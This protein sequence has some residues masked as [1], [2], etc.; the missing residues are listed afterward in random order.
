MSK[1]NIRQRSK[2]DRVPYELWASQGLITLTYAYIIDFDVIESSI[3]NDAKD[4]EIIEIGYD[5]WKAIEIVT[6]LKKKG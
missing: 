2:E 5:P 6:H 1:E 4:F 3:L